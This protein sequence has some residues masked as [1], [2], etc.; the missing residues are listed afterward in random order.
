MGTYT[1]TAANDTI[2]PVTVSP[3]VTVTGAPKPSIGADTIGGLGGDD[4][5]NGGGGADT[6]NGGYGNDS[7]GCYVNTNAV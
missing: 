3:G 6:I 2:T 1:G 5:L 4:V 7:V